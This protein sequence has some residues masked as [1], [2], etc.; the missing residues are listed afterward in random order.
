MTCT[1]QMRRSARPQLESLDGRVLPSSGMSFAAREAVIEARVEELH[2]LREAKIEALN[3]VRAARLAAREAA[4]AARAQVREIRL[5][6][7]VE[8]V[9]AP[10]AP[11]VA[12]PSFPAPTPTTLNPAPNPTPTTTTTSPTQS[13]TSGST[14]PGFTPTSGDVSNAQ[15]GPLAIAGT[16]LTSLYQQYQTYMAEGGTATDFN[17]SVDGVS[18]SNGKVDVDLSALGDVT[19]YETAVEA[20][21]MDVQH[22]DTTTG[23]IEGLLPIGELLNVA[24]MGTTVGIMPIMAPVSR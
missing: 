3:A 21:G 18:A 5:V 2:A 17:A 1:R 12:N 11:I 9:I 20:L 16:A 6:S 23:L 14:T 4:L 15:G 24:Q 10:V 13:A 19:T 22:A 7:S 8:A